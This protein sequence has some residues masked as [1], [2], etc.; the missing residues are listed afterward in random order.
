MALNALVGFFATIRKK[1]KSVG[2]KGLNVGKHKPCALPSFLDNE[3]Q[4]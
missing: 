3:T 1:C 4:I 2:L